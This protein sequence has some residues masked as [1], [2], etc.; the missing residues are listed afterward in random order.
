MRKKTLAWIVI[1][2]TLANLT[3][4]ATM[5]YLKRQN[6]NSCQPGS[7]FELV[8][9]EVG[10]NPSQIE[11]FQV[12][13]KAFHKELDSLE[14]LLYKQRRELSLEIRKENPDSSYISQIMEQVGT[15]QQESQY[16]VINHFF[17]IKKIL[18]PEQ[19]AIFFNLTLEDCFLRQQSIRVY[20]QQNV[21]RQ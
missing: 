20:Q 13:R 12:N 15:L 2:I 14:Q 3:S 8:K 6:N 17:Q 19:Q 16:R 1:F 11:Q 21:N 18:T 9:K 10:L 7:R 5:F 4:L